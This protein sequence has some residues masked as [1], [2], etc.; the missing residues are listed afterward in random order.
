MNDLDYTFLG[1]KE[2]CHFKLFYEHRKPVW[3][4][5]GDTWYVFLY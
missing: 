4:D 5:K 2:H 3:D 1:C